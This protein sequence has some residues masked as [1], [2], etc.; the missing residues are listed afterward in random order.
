[1]IRRQPNDHYNMDIISYSDINDRGIKDY[2][3][4]SSKGVGKFV[5]AKPV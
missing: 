5:N 2:Y 3:T 1:M 4:F